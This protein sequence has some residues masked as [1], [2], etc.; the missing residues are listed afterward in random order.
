M[1]DTHISMLRAHSRHRDYVRLALLLVSQAL[2]RR[3]VIHDT[4]KMQDDE[5]EGYARIHGA[6]VGLSFGSPEQR[7]V[8][9]HEQAT[10]DLHHLR[11]SHHPEH[12][13][14]QGQQAE[15]IR[16]L[17]DDCVYW[18]ARAAAALTFID[19]IEMV[20]DW[21]GAWQGY[22]D[23]PMTWDKTV[24]VS[25][26]RKAAHLTAEQ[27]WLVREVATFIGRARV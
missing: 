8:V 6:M 25:L 19:L 2:D 11:N 17:P 26:E 21:R 13:A 22:G 3:A 24:E 14:L 10:V 15:T 18:T 20:C 23:N 7:D 1:S 16:G 12:P 27:Q 9:T 5:Y 4:S